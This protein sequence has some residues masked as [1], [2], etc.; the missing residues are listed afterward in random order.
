MD[1]GDYALRKR[2]D[3]A[4]D[5]DSFCLWLWLFAGRLGLVFVRSLIMEMLWFISIVQL[6]FGDLNVMLQCDRSETCNSS[7]W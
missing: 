7:A 1:L 4:F 3:V 6:W 2:V 5:L